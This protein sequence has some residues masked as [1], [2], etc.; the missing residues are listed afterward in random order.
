MKRRQDMEP[1]AEAEGCTVII[2]PLRWRKGKARRTAEVYLSTTAKGR[3]TYWKRISADLERQL[4]RLGCTEDDIA[5]E[6]E[7]FTATVQAEI[8]RMHRRR[9]EP[10]GAA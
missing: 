5:R 9:P 1:D 4:E 3:T 6:M 2:F 7:G 10:D 8:D